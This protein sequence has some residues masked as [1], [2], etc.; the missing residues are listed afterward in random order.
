MHGFAYTQMFSLNKY[1]AGIQ[2]YAGTPLVTTV[3]NHP[4]SAH[5]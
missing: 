1:V 2:F 3:Y 5:A 4:V